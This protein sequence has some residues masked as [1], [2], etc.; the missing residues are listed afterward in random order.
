MDYKIITFGETEIKKHKFHQHKSP[1]LI[2]NIDNNKILV[3]NKVS[4]V[5]KEI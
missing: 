3:C 2:Y 5:K 1:I 4:F